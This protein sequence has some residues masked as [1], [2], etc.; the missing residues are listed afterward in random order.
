MLEMGLFKTGPG[1][2]VATAGPR[3]GIQLHLHRLDGALPL[4][5]STL[6]PFT[7]PKC[8][9]GCQWRGGQSKTWI[10]TSFPSISSETRGKRLSFLFCGILTSALPTAQGCKEQ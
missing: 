2:T 1:I 3:T 4:L 5:S 8:L 9:P 10:K 7:E 6:L